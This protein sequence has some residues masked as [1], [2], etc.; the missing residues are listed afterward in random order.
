MKHILQFSYLY[1]NLST[2]IVL[3]ILGLFVYF[4]ARFLAFVFPSAEKKNEPE[5]GIMT[6]IDAA[7]NR[8]NKHVR[9]MDMF[10]ERPKIIIHEPPKVLQ[11]QS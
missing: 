1:P 9:Q 10:N 7:V 6:N 5:P 11:A 2:L 3:L 8:I 4:F